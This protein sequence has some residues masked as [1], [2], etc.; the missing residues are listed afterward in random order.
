MTILDLF[1]VCGRSC[2]LDESWLQLS[3]AEEED[4][5]LEEVCME[6]ES[7]GVGVVK[8]RSCT[9][10]SACVPH[11][12][13]SASMG[14][15]A[16]QAVTG[17]KGLLLLWMF[18]DACSR[19]GER[20]HGWAPCLCVVLGAQAAI[21]HTRSTAQGQGWKVGDTRTKRGLDAA[22]VA[23]ETVA[24]VVVWLCV[25]AGPCVGGVCVAA[26][27]VL[28]RTSDVPVA[29]THRTNNAATTTNHSRGAQV[30]AVPLLLHLSLYICFTCRCICCPDVWW[31]GVW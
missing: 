1:W 9:L 21:Q 24:H 6:D 22:A 15:A 13:L 26:A 10:T 12:P 25:D 11:G 8:S 29:H 16:V 7:G 2:P 17:L 28:A 30:R 27:L 18:G 31:C 20:L 14:D 5:L 3:V 4:G 23:W 19:G